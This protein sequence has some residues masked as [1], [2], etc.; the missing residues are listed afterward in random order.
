MH[1]SLHDGQGVAPPVDRRAMHRLPAA[2][3]ALVRLSDTL[4]FRC[5]LR[6]ISTAAAQ[7]VC[8]ARYALLIQAPDDGRQ[9]A[10]RSLEISIAL[11]VDGRVRG[12]TAFCAARYCVPFEEHRMMLG[13]Q[14][15]EIDRLA[16]GL[17]DDYL[18][19]RGGEA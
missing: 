18:A 19:Q 17:L 9:S 16:R 12:F 15:V 11:S 1:T 10:N 4:T 13:L 7:V 3:N 8:D 2:C 5:M 14:F 6:N